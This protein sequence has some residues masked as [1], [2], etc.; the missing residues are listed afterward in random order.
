MKERLIEEQNA[1]TTLSIEWIIGN[2]RRV[3]MALHKGPDLDTGELT[4][5]EI[6]TTPTV[7]ECV[8]QAIGPA[9]LST[10]TYV[11]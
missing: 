3:D 1:L 2:N 6:K 7:E 4:F 5:Y 9:N 11:D 10:I 8:R